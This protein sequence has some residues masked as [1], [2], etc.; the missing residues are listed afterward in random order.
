MRGQTIEDQPLKENEGMCNPLPAPSVMGNKKIRMIA[1][2]EHCDSGQYLGLVLSF[3]THSDS[4]KIVLQFDNKAYIYI[5]KVIPNIVQ[6]ITFNEKE[7]NLQLTGDQK[8]KMVF[9]IKKIPTYALG[10]SYELRI[11]VFFQKI[12]LHSDPALFTVD[13]L[14]EIAHPIDSDSTFIGTRLNEPIQ[15][16]KPVEI[17]EIDRSNENAFIRWLKANGLLLTFGLVL[18]VLLLFIYKRFAGQKG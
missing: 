18:I 4:S 16:I 5:D 3:L 12:S 14:N 6:S 11:A 7:S 15:E 13:Y 9:D 1:N 2:S 17:L 8:G 10:S